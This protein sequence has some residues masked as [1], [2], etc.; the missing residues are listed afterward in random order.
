YLLTF[1][2]HNS[3]N[4][5]R[6]F[7][8]AK[9]AAIAYAPLLTPVLNLDMPRLETVLDQADPTL[10]NLFAY[11]GQ[12][13]FSGVKHPLG[14][15]AKAKAKGWCVLLDAAAFVPTDRLDL[16][17]VQPDFVTISF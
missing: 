7:A 6:E 15:V 10:N 9:G 2:N 12:S 16:M 5:I 3:V 14:L 11:P 1:D 17:A 8:R 4:G 13:N